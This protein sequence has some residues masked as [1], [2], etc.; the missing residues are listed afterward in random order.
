MLTEIDRDG[1][2]RK[3]QSGKEK[4]AQVFKDNISVKRKQVYTWIEG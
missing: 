1:N 4:S 2:N 3:E